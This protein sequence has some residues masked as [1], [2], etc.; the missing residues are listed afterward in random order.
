MR[1]RLLKSRQACKRKE[2]KGKE[3][4]SRVRVGRLGQARLPLHTWI[5]TFAQLLVGERTVNGWCVVYQPVVVRQEVE[6]VTPGI[7][8]EQ[9]KNIHFFGVKFLGFYFVF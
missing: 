9:E 7:R 2:R 6:P 3:K 4:M 1:F 8:S 5:H